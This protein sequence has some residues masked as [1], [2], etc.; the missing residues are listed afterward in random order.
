[1][2]ISVICRTVRA[3]QYDFERETDWSVLIKTVLCYTVEK[4]SI[5]GF[6]EPV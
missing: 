3:R 4:V 1:M 6:R 5:N 2:N